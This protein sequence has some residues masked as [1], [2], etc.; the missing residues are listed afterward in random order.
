MCIY[1]FIYIYMCIYVI[2]ICFTNLNMCNVQFTNNVIYYFSVHSITPVDAHRM[3]SCD[4]T[5]ISII[6]V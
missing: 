2:I 6:N 1:T 5:L 3:S 4:Q